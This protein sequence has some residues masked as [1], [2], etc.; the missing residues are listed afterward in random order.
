MNTPAIVL[1]QRRVGQLTTMRVA[2]IVALVGEGAALMFLQTVS[3]GF[4]PILTGFVVVA[5]V[6]AAII[7]TG[8]R[9]TPLLAVLWFALV[10]GG[11]AQYLAYDL[12]HPALFDHFSFSVVFTAIALVGV[13][14]GVAALVQQ[15]RSDNP[16]TPRWFWPFVIALVALSTGAVAVSWL[17]AG[18][19]GSGVSAETLAQLP[20]LNTLPNRFDQ[21]EIR[22]HVGETVALRLQNEDTSAHSFDIDQL[23]V[24]TA[25]PVGTTNLALFRPS[26]PG[27]YTFYCNIPGHREAGMEGT[28]IVEP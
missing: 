12:A 19:A 16:G 7:A 1:P 10:V 15:K 17:G 27:S 25:M 22:A 21:N 18:S 14:G 28:L 24:H 20:A 8:R 3:I 5:L 11:N 4:E 23:N 6:F 9:W 13:V 2:S 26:A